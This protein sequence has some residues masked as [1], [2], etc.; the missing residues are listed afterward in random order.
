MIRTLRYFVILVVAGVA[1]IVLGGIAMGQQVDERLS[2]VYEV[3]VEAI[4]VPTDHTSIERGQHLVDT[5]LFCKECHGDDLSGQLQFNDPLTGRISSGN[6]TRGK[7]GIGSETSAA[8][9]WG[10]GS[11]A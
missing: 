3:P 1:L 6:L 9:W 8:R 7:G 2:I 5:V 10:V 11:I 4:E